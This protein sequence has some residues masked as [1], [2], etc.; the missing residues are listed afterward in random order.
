MELHLPPKPAPA[1]PPGTFCFAAAGLAHGHIYGMVDGLLGAGAT[2]RAVWDADPQK[3]AAFCRRFPQA[4]AAAS[5]QELLDDPALRLVASAAVPSER[6]PLGLRVM[7]AGKD[8]FVDKAP[9]TTLDQL[10]AARRAVRETGRKYMVYYS[11]RLHSEAATL[12]DH[13]IRQGAIGRV[14]HIEGF[15]PHRLGEER[16]AWFYEK[17]R[18]GGILC[19]IGSH[20]LEQFL[21]FT[22]AEKA[23]ITFARK[24]N[25]AHPSHPAFEDLGECTV[26]A[27][28]GATGY[29]RVD[30][31]TP[32]GLRNW[33]DGRTFL[34]GTDGYIELRK[35]IDLAAG[36]KRENMVYWANKQGEFRFDATGQVGYPFFSRLIRDCLEGTQTAMTQEHA[37]Q[38]A[39]LCLKAQALADEQALADQKE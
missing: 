2:L 1:V 21:Y 27:A 16:P 7:G 30:W 37:F 22:G 38:A 20:Q 11:E 31:F 39:E 19:D 29:F 18:Y 23:K 14:I 17:A 26:T 10:A 32:D 8:Y 36:E 28:N 4:R 5:V 35:Y 33:G 3:V 25:Y 15:G 13:L 6:C 9:M 24:A 12:A 34:L